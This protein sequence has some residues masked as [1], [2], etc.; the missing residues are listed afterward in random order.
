[1]ETETTNRGRAPLGHKQSGHDPVGTG[2]SAA[3]G[4]VSEQFMAGEESRK[5]MR[6]SGGDEAEVVTTRV[7]NRWQELRA[8][9]IVQ[10]HI[11]S[12][13]VRVELTSIAGSTLNTNQQ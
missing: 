10:R 7:T 6:R 8:G 5:S 3:E 12:E 9:S 13:L 2:T 4:R 1:M 11:H